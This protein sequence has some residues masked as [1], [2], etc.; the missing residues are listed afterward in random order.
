MSS[1]E[2]Q[3]LCLGLCWHCLLNTSC[4]VCAMLSRALLKSGGHQG[5]LTLGILL[6]QLLAVAQLHLKVWPCK[7]THAGVKQP[8]LMLKNFC[9][10]HIV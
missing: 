7:G 4:I 8:I 3:H 10:H 5:F 9:D 2:E 1:F 6:I